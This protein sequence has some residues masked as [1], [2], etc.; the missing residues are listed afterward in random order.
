MNG[1]DTVTGDSLGANLMLM[2]PPRTEAGLAPGPWLKLSRY[3]HSGDFT[4]RRRE[5]A[6]GLAGP[7]TLSDYLSMKIFFNNNNNNDDNNRQSSCHDLFIFEKDI[8][9]LLRFAEPFL[10]L[11]CFLFLGLCV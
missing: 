10:N 8:T 7:D 11:A 5:G 4:V 1:A 2:D 9:R 3:Q 6:W